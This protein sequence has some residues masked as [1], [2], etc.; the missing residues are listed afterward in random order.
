M[1]AQPS[2]AGGPGR[3][4]V[5]SA[6]M[7]RII[8]GLADVVLRAG[9]V[10]ARPEDHESKRRAA[11]LSFYRDSHAM[12]FCI[13]F[14][15]FTA[16]PG[17][18]KSLYSATRRAVELLTSAPVQLPFPPCHSG[19][20]SVQVSRGPKPLRLGRLWCTQAP[21]TPAFEKLLDISGL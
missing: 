9:G 3:E 20:T 2:G 4:V 15:C 12:H 10:G 14:H 5:V 8:R 17:D 6:A 18:E 1:S 11:I 16:G 13:M 19:S 21:S 7:A